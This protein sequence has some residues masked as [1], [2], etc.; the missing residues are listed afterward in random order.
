M[1]IIFAREHN[2]TESFNNIRLNIKF[3]KNYNLRQSRLF[4][5]IPR[6]SRM[7]LITSFYV[8]QVLRRKSGVIFKVLQGDDDWNYK[9][10]KDTEVENPKTVSSSGKYIILN[11]NL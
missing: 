3:L 4:Q 1:P 5:D 7:K 9:W 11:I 2:L 6:H 10:R 8:V